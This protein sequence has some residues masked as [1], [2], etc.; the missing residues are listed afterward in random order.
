MKACVTHLADEADAAAAGALQPTALTEA[1]SAGLSSSST[2]EPTSPK[3]GVSVTSGGSSIGGGG[4]APSARE[5]GAAAARRRAARMRAHAGKLA[6]LLHGTS[7]EAWG[8]QRVLDKKRDPTTRAL[9]DATVRGD[10]AARLSAGAYSAYWDGLCLA[11]R[12]AVERAL[13][14]EGIGISDGGGGGGGVALVA[15]YPFFR[16]AF[17]HL[18]RRLEDGK[19]GPTQGS[20]RGVG[21]VSSSMA[22][23]SG[24]D[25]KMDPA[26][27]AGSVPSWS[28]ALISAGS[29]GFSGGS[30]SGTAAGGVGGGG[31]VLGGSAWLSLALDDEED[32]SS[33]GGTQGGGNRRRVGEAAAE[34]R[35]GPSE[36]DDSRRGHGLRRR[37]GQ[38]DGE[39]PSVGGG[40]G[41]SSDCARLLAALGPLRDLFLARSLERLTT[42]VE[43]MFPQV[44]TDHAQLTLLSEAA[45]H[46]ALLPFIM[47]REMGFSLDAFELTKS[48][49]TFNGNMKPILK[50]SDVTSLVA[51]L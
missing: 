46:F 21:G 36:A 1:T 11:V 28:R 49:H 25:P 17:L 48:R 41:K 45:V 12:G 34:A 18:I 3:P 6:T 23:G 26:G 2:T 10:R 9:L 19:R 44:R 40:G 39:G 29:G 31:G 38:G 37:D 32:Y 7:M 8:L 33:L 51:F 20:S 43:Q 35:V 30:Q 16:K 4:R 24:D 22:G 13:S 5:A 50:F 27:R 42:P 14:S 47:S 15:M